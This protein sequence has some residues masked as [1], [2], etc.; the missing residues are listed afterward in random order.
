MKLITLQEHDLF[1]VER[2]QAF[3]RLTLVEYAKRDTGWAYYASYYIGA[4][5]IDADRALVVTPKRGMEHIDFLSM[6]GS[7]LDAGLSPESFAEI[8]RINIDDP[9][10]DAPALAAVLSP[11][12][13]FHFLATVKKIKHLKKEYVSRSE[14]LHKVKGRIAAMKNERTNIMTRRFDRMYCNYNEY[15]TDTPENRVIKKALLF[16]ERYLGRMGTN[17]SIREAQTILAGCLRKFEGVSEQISINQVR[18]VEANVLYR[19]HGEAVRLAKTILRY[20]DYSISKA[21]TAS[22]QVIPFRLDMSLLYEHYVL[23]LL[24][25][26][27]PGAIRYQAEGSTGKPDFLYLSPDFKA[28]LDTKYMPKYQSQKL[29]TDVIRQLAGYSRDLKIL[30]CLGIEACRNSLLPPVPC[31]IIYPVEKSLSAL[32]PFL[33]APLQSVLMP[34]KGLLNFYTIE[35]PV[36]TL[37]I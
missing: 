31:I 9:P 3:D 5:W 24:Y 33:S 2:S 19:T 25:K 28:I 32:N 22:A 21:E 4:E 12:L 26:A 37:Q 23:G 1:S 6:F 17:N 16:A 30:H 34:A 11:L 13:I 7:C 27:Y 10:V 36:P 14:N 8:Y 35:I 20:F 29:D 18:N 15:T